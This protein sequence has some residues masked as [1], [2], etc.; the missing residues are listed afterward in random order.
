MFCLFSQFCMMS[1]ILLPVHWSRNRVLEGEKCVHYYLAA[2][3]DLFL[4]W[5]WISPLIG[6][7]PFLFNQS[8]ACNL[9][10]PKRNQFLKGTCIFLSLSTHTSWSLMLCLPKEYCRKEN[11]SDCSP[12][13]YHCLFFA[14]DFQKHTFGWT[15]WDKLTWIQGCLSI[16]CA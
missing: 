12:P 3:G 14:L 15:S 2:L 9:P 11:G 1:N 7:L 10:S 16:C 8:L 13:T 6:T 4:G 5:S